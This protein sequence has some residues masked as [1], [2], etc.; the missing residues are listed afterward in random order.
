M[1]QWETDEQAEDEDDAAAL[2][3]DY[4]YVPARSSTQRLPVSTPRSLPLLK[5]CSSSN[6][7]VTLVM[8]HHD[9]RMMFG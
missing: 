6:G 9:T 5:I 4:G 3:I 2:D 1:R 7:I 8:N